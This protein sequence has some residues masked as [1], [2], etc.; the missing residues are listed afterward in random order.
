[1]SHNYLLDLNQ[2]ID[3][4]ISSL[5]ISTKRASSSVEERRRSE[6]GLDAL[7]GFQALLCRD[8]YP[9]LPQRLYRRLMATSCRAADL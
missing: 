6:G 9:K 4:R 5:N 8:L 7:E 3:T 2:Y 1:M